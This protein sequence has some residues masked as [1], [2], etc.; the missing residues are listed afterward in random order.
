[1]SEAKKGVDVK[2]SLDVKKVMRDVRDAGMDAWAKVMLR[3]TYSHKYQRLQGLIA[4]PSLLAIG[5]FRKTTESAMSGVLAQLNMP[6]RGEVLTLSQ[7]MTHN[8]MVLD[9]LG[10]GFDQLRRSI[11]TTRPQRT[12]SRDRDIGTEPPHAFSAKQA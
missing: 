11:P 4:K 9:D 1:M 8:E 7:R 3:L 2:K 6:S 10:A 5:L 12:P